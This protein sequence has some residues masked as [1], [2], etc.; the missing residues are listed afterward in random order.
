[1]ADGDD[2]GEYETSDPS[3]QAGDEIR[4]D[5]N[6]RLLVRAGVSLPVAEEFLDAPTHGVLEVEPL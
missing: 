1:M 5:G 6:R 3:L 4:A 2:A